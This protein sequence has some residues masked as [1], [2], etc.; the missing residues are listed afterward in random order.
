MRLKNLLK[1]YFLLTIKDWSGLFIESFASQRLLGSTVSWL[2][3]S[4]L[5]SSWRLPI[6]AWFIFTLSLDS[7]RFCGSVVRFLNSVA[8][9]PILEGPE[10]LPVAVR[11]GLPGAERQDLKGEEVGV[12]QEPI[13]TPSSVRISSWLIVSLVL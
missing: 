6:S 5:A 10:R 9:P 1:V 3:F 8:L 12:L 2:Q 13:R 7:H 4:L 11:K